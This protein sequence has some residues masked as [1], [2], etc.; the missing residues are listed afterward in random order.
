MFFLNCCIC[1]D[2]NLHLLAAAYQADM[3]KLQHTLAD[4]TKLKGL[5]DLSDLV[6]CSPAW[7]LFSDHKTFWIS[8]E[9]PINYAELK[10]CKQIVNTEV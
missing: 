1:Q 8:Q 4:V 3:A 5:S 10:C 6:T 2:V 9:P 7:S